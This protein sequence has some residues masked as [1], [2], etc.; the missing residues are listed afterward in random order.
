MTIKIWLIVSGILSALVIA[1]PWLVFI[2]MFMLVV[3]GLILLAAPTVFMYLATFSVLRMVLPMPPGLM[4]NAVAAGLTLFLGWAVVQPSVW[5]AKR[6]FDRANL[7]EIIPA[8]PV[9]LKGHIRLVMRDVSISRGKSR[10]LTCNALCAAVLA[11]PGVTAVTLV[12]ARA[13]KPADP[14][15]FRLVPKSAAREQGLAPVKPESILDHLPQ[16]P[17][18]AGSRDFDVE[19]AERTRV[20]EAAAAAWAVRLATRE[21]LIA[22]PANAAPDMAILIDAGTFTGA[23]G[24]LSRV[25]ILDAGDRVVMR[26]SILSVSTLAAP[27]HVGTQGNLSNF[28]LIWARREFKTAPEYSEL[29]PITELFV[30]STLA[31]PSDD[32]Q[33]ASELRARLDEALADPA[34][35]A[36]DADFSLAQVW[37]STTDWRQPLSESDR[38]LLARA[39]ADPRIPIPRQLYDGNQRQVDVSLRAA[40]GSRIVNPLTLEEERRQLALLL[41][42][43]PK[44]TFATLTADERHFLGNGKLRAQTTPMLARLADRGTA[45]VADLLA[46]LESDSKIEPWAKRWQSLEALC[47]AFTRLGPDAAAALPV[48][49]ELVNRERSPLLNT[50]NNRQDWNFALVRMGRLPD[51]INFPNSTPENTIQNRQYLRDRVA[52]FDK[53]ADSD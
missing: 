3:P 32:P 33:T 49:S 21:T 23:K 53:S 9:A 4:L 16:T 8:T 19:T 42:N 2:G 46:I 11:T 26:R 18:P 36:T 48:V 41:S 44:G 29:K 35:A 5:T 6:A 14:V 31:R 47:R 40:I 30:H 10:T 20:R 17:K 39:I 52:R 22:E 38:S 28:K 27:L 50:W 1:M 24:S 37:F 51:N 7:P 34:R 15:T 13:D 25:E 45:A 12:S 43:M